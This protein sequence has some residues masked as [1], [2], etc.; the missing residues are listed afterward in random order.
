MG[1]Y[2]QREAEVNIRDHRGCFNCRSRASWATG[3]EKGD[4]RTLV[5]TAHSIVEL[6]NAPTSFK[7]KFAAQRRDVGAAHR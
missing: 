6:S 3:R 1:D 4:W 5:V 7:G 2:K